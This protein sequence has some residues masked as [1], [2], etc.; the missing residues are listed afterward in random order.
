MSTEAALVVIN[1]AVVV[2]HILDKKRNCPAAA[3]GHTTHVAGWAAHGFVRPPPR[4][5]AEMAL[6]PPWLASLST[7][8]AGVGLPL[9]ENNHGCRRRHGRC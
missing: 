1:V 4:L 3:G 6:A 2:V 7:P 8:A 5:A 9:K